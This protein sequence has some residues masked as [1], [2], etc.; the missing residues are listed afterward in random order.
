MPYQITLP[1]NI[2]SIAGENSG[3]K[4]WK[5]QIFG[6]ANQPNGPGFRIAGE[7]SGQLNNG[8]DHIVLYGPVGETILD[9]TYSDDWFH[10]TDGLGF[11]LI[12]R[13]LNTPGT[14]YS[15]S[16]TWRGSTYQGGSPGVADL[17]SPGRSS[18]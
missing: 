3:R 12:N 8:G 5:I 1:K 18:N 2:M 13:D 7:Y 14:N 9:F 10:Q 15:S 4:I 17:V 11:S 16:G 6:S